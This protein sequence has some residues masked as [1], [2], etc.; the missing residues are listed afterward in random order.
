M[1]SAGEG[2][3]GVMREVAADRLEGRRGD[4]QV[5]IKNNCTVQEV[6]FYLISGTRLY[7]TSNCTTY[8]VAFNKPYERS[9]FCEHY[10]LDVLY[11]VFLSYTPVTTC[12]TICTVSFV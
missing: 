9:D 12:Q 11:W 2:V 8:Q 3:P 10:V 4:A 7:S 5:R 1:L 6:L